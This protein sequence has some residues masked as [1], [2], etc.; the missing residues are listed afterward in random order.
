MSREYWAGMILAAVQRGDIYRAR[1][2]AELFAQIE[3]GK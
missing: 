1:Q 2:L 3:K